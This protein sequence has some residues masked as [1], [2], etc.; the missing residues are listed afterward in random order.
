MSWLMATGSM[1]ERLRRVEQALLGLPDV[2]GVGLGWKETRGEVTDR[3]AWRVYVRR[4]LPNH[5][6]RFADLVPAYVEGLATDVLPAPF[7]I[8]AASNTVSS[9]LAPGA[10][11]SNLRGL[12]HDMSVN[13]QTSG[14]GTLGFLGFVNGTRR[15][16][17][18]LVSNRH[19]LLA[20]GAGRGD[21]IYQPVFS[22]RGE[23]YVVRADALDPVAEILQ[24]GAEANHF[25]Q[26]AR[27]VPGDYF[28]DCASAR[29][30]VERN[31]HLR[32]RLPARNAD[33]DAR[34][35]GIARVHPLD[36]VGGRAPR[37]RK[38][39][40]VTGVTAGCV[41]DVAA[42]VE[43]AG[44]PRRLNNIVIRGIDGPLV[45]PGDSGALVVN[46]RDEAIGLLWG[47]SEHDPR[48]AYACH[49]HPVLDRLKVTM[50][51]GGLS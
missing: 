20:R 6:M 24:E 45:E 36:V 8:P 38:I 37:V 32:P 25:F 14:L 18:V 47:R 35:R 5:A 49:I 22:E 33:G 16:D 43:T 21:P 27:E 7:S 46:D 48:I 11:I 12:L 34:I 50:M 44:Q 28:I 40:S 23:K 13:C 30:L 19:V 1:Q 41:V 26:Y 51:A 2:T 9:P 31:V 4:K 17:V 10:V 39:G 42:P 29:V 3:A 15:P